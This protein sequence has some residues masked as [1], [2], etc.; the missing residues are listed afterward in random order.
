MKDQELKKMRKL[1]SVLS[2]EAKKKKWGK[3]YDKKY[4]E[5]M[6]KAREAKARKKELLDNK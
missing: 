4:K 6:A 3:D 1:L 2:H 5:I